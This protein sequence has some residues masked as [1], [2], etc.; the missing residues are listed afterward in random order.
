MNLHI[1]EAQRTLGRKNTQIHSE[2]CSN[3]TFKSQSQRKNLESSKRELNVL[4]QGD[5]LKKAG[6]LSRNHG[7][8]KAVR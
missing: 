1:Q 5:S 8:Q 7:G 6:H 2:T 4:F 3:K